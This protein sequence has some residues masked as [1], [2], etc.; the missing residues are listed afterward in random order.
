MNLLYK[1]SARRTSR[2]RVFI[3]YLLQC[4]RDMEAPMDAASGRASMDRPAWHV[5]GYGRASATMRSHR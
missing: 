5:R 2:V 1:G 4:L 3:D